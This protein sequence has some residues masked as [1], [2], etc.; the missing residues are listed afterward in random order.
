MSCKSQL[1]IFLSEIGK[2]CY[3]MLPN[4]HKTSKDIQSKMQYFVRIIFWVLESGAAWNLDFFFK[5]SI[6]QPIHQGV[7]QVRRL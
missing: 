7:F 6:S 3:L 1:S 5:F 2:C 4:P